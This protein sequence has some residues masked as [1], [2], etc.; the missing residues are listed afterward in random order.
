MAVVSPRAAT[1]AA[2]ARAPGLMTEHAVM[3]AAVTVAASSRTVDRKVP[4]GISEM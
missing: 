4:R 1:V 3:D 2:D